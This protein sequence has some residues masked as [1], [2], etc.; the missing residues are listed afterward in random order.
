MSDQHEH[1][2]TP[3]WILNSVFFALMVLTVLTVAAIKIDLGW[4]NIY[5]A[6]GIACVKALLVVFFFM[7]LKW[8]RAFHTLCCISSLVFVGIFMG[9]IL[10]DSG[11]YRDTIEDYDQ[12]QAAAVES[13]K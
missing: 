13:M 3:A 12:D 8:D 9:Y 5:L 11:E 6:V 7:H 2:L 10:V 4:L 1:H